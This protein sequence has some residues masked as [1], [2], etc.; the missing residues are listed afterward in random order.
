LHQHV[1][2]QVLKGKAGKLIV[3]LSHNLPLHLP[4]GN[5]KI[6]LLGF[7]QGSRAVKTLEQLFLLKVF[8]F[9]DYCWYFFERLS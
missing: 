1:R 2:A 8:D 7:V 5:A 9:Y 4:Q 6:Y 3:S